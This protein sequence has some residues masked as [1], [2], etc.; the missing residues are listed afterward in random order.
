[1]SFDV[2]LYF[3]RSNT[4]KAVKDLQSLGTLTGTLKDSTS[5]TNP[6]IIIRGNIS[7]LLSCNY[8]KIP[9][10][11]R[12]YFI[13]D[14]TSV[15][16]GVIEVSGHTDVLSSWWLQLAQ[17][18]CIV[19]RNQNRWNTFLND[20]TFKTYEQKE[21]AAI[22]FPNGFSGGSYVMAVVGG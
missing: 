21:I 18:E 13:T 3:N 7:G 12:S 16:E 1:M 8:F 17:C 22:E 2:N 6:T 15:R 20:G 10:F 19:E 11:N 9:S 4:K 14:I 5:I